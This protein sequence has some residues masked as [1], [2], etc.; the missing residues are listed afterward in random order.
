MR[1]KMLESVAIAGIENPSDSL[2]FGGKL[3]PPAKR[4]SSDWRNR[5]QDPPSTVEKR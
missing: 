1:L 4:S 3:R 5:G 2:D